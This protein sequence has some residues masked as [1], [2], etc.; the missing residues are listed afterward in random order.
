MQKNTEMTVLNVSGLNTI[1][2]TQDGIARAVNDVSF[3]MNPGETLG[4]VGESGSGKSVT[5]LSIMRL[6][7]HPGSI[8]SGQIMFDGRD[9][10]QLSERQMQDVRGNRI[11]MIFQ[12]PMTSLNPLKKI[13]DQIGEMF[14][15]HTDLSRKECSNKAVSMLERVQI[16][17][18]L[19]RAREYPHQLSGGMRQRVMI[20]MALAC[21]PEI[22]IADEP[23]TALDVT[24]QAQVLDL[25]LT[26]KSEIGTGILMITHDLGVVAQ[27]AQQVIVMY[28]GEIVESGDVFSIFEHP[29]H[30]Y[31]K[32]LLNSTLKP[33]SKQ[34]QKRKKLQEI[35]GM[36]PSLY[37]LPSGCH[38]FERCP[39]AV[40][41]CL[42]FEQHLKDVGNGCLV[43]CIKFEDIR[44]KD[45]R[46]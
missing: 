17:S 38:F 37:D 46:V 32:A 28:A 14:I 44:S 24:I 39:E 1:F 41:E 8:A 29:K 34:G 7:D 23:T 43:R 18:P 36:V 6:I 19:K 40:E 3:C 4:I 11:S 10:L 15:K 35:Q 31:T 30:P 42:R 20:A 33:G 12:E 27:I 45:G 13:G 2:Q 16:P 5:A 9:L 25:M 21:N 22:L 26:L